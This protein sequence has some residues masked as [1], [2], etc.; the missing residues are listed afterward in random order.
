MTEKE[1]QNRI[2]YRD[3]LIIIIDKP[4]GIPVHGGPNGGENLE[5]YFPYLQFGLKNPPALAHRLDRDTSGC[6]VLGRNHKGLKKMGKLF[7]KGEVHK[8]YMAIISGVMPEETGVIDLPLKKKS[9]EKSGWKMIVSNDG[10][11][12]VTEYKVLKT[13]GKISLVECYPQTGRTHQIRVHFAEK[14]CPIL[15]DTAYGRPLI[16]FDVPSLMLH[17]KAIEFLLYLQKEKVKVEAPPPNS[18]QE[19]INIL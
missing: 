12:A 3:G 11:R 15:G 14:G 6:L 19:I 17:A 2:L 16:G 8:T 9:S 13:N 1:M 7:E 10:Q 18:M 4:A 5:Q